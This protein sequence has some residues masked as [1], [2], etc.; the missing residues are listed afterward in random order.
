VT[1]PKQV[2]WPMDGQLPPPGTSGSVRGI[3]F[4]YLG[5][6]FPRTN[7]ANHAGKTPSASVAL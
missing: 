6:N 4:R 5:N 3:W 2:P 7:A 1:D